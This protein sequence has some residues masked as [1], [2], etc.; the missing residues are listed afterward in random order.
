[1]S[2]QTEQQENHK[3]KKT[4]KQIAALACIVLLVGLY[5]GALVVACLDFGDSGQL[6]AGWL[7]SMIGLP[8]LLWLLIW[9][10]NLLKKRRDENR[11]PQNSDSVDEDD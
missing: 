5:V 8:I 2:P 9:S 4:A 6:F 1:M 10:L 7:G 11:P 3:K